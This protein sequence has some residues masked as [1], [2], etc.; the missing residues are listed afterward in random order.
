MPCVEKFNFIAEKYMTNK[1]IAIFT[2]PVGFKP[3]QEACGTA[4]EHFAI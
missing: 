3:G 4:S 1:E 2:L